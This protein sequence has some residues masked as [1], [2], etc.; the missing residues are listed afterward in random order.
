MMAD[1]AGEIAANY[2]HQRRKLCFKIAEAVYEHVRDESDSFD[3]ESIAQHVDMHLT[4][5]HIEADAYMDELREKWNRQDTEQRKP[6][7]PN[8]LR[9]ALHCTTD[10]SIGCMM[11]A[12]I[13][14][15]A[16]RDRLREVLQ[17]YEQW[18]ADAV[19]DDNCWRDSP[20]VLTQ[21]QYDRLIELQQLRN[22]ALNHT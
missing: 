19:M 11:Q 8:Q 3:T 14:C 21:P 18:E 2:L 15:V 12:A 6:S 13:D 4:L 9:E 22:A 5:T 10:M 20:M 1:K 7:L 17:G 16:E